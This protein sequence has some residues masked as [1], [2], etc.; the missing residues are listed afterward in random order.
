[1]LDD[2]YKG[3]TADEIRSLHG[4]KP[5]RTNSRAFD[6]LALV[7]WSFGSGL[8]LGQVLISIAQGNIVI[9]IMCGTTAVVGIAATYRY[10]YLLMQKERYEKEEDSN[11]SPAPR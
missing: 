10:S 1:M 11:E 3:P 9:A 8:N 7:A 2:R 4:Y 5:R 6:T